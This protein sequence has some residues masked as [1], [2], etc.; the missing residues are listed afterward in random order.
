MAAYSDSEM[1]HML[2]SRDPRFFSALHERFFRILFV[3]C[4][5]MGIS[6]LDSEE[7]VNDVF[8]RLYTVNRSKVFLSWVEIN[9]YLY[10]SVKNKSITF[11]E[12]N[13]VAEKRANK[14]LADFDDGDY[15]LDLLELKFREIAWASNTAK[16]KGILANT[17]FKCL[18]ILRMMYYEGKTVPEIAS[19]MGI[20]QQTVRN[21]KAKGLN[22][23]AGILR[24]EDFLLQSLFLVIYILSAI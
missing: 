17:S 7:I 22:M 21:A 5:K 18:D 4:R 15:V 12:S 2:N 11:L 19:Q 23:M 24:P 14:V 1:V 10:K 13:K 16:L 20:S 3:H 9:N 6:S 8:Y